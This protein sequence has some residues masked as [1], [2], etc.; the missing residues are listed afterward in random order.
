MWPSRASLTGAGTVPRRK[1]C[2]PTGE[3][4][5]CVCPVPD[6]ALTLLS[7][8]SVPQ[9]LPSTRLFVL[10]NINWSS[11]RLATDRTTSPP[12]QHW[13]GSGALAPLCPHIRDKS[14]S[15]KVR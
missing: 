9:S 10:L 12:R 13:A 14:K 2:V 3:L 7:P 11:P 6:P 4:E 15:K 8:R 1:L 5:G